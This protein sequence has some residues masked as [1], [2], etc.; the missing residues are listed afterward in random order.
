M[1]GLASLTMPL[2]AL[3]WVLVAN[4]DDGEEEDDTEEKDLFASFLL[5]DI[6]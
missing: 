2:G 5:R 4:Y 3:L 1:I 6:L